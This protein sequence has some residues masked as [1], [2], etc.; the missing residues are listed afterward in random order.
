MLLFDDK[1]RVYVK[2]ESW[3]RGQEEQ[4]KDEGN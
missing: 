3:E 2:R 4:S 1:G